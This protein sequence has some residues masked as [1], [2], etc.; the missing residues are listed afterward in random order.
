MPQLWLND[1]NTVR[2]TSKLWVND[3]GTIRE[4]QNLWA[5][6]GGTVRLVYTGLNGVVLSATSAGH[7]VVN[8]LNS[9]R[10]IRASDYITEG[11]ILVLPDDWWIWSDDTAAPA[12]ILDVANMTFINNGNVIGRGGD[13][14]GNSQ[15]AEAGGPAIQVTAAGVTIQN[16]AGA[17]IAGGGGGGAGS[18]NTAGGGG[19]G[20]GQGGDR[21]NA[22][23]GG[24]GGTIGLA[25]AAGSGTAIY[26]EAGAFIA[27]GGGGGAG[28]VNTAG[29]GGAGGGQG[30]DRRNA[31]AG[32]VGGT[33][34]QAGAAGSGTAIYTAAG[35]GA[36]G[37]GGYFDSDSGNGVSAGGGGRILPGVGGTVAG[38]R[39][40]LQPPVGVGGSADDPGN[41]GAGQG[42]GSRG[43]GGG[44]WGA[45]GGNFF[46]AVGGAGG[47]SIDGAPTVTNN[48]TI[49][50][51]GSV[52]TLLFG[53]V[54]GGDRGATA[55][56]TPATP[57]TIPVGATAVFNN[58]SSGTSNPLK[59]AILRFDGVEVARFSSGAGGT[60]GSFCRT[61]GAATSTPITLTG[62]P[63]T[64]TTITLQVTGAAATRPDLAAMCPANISSSV[65][66]TAEQMF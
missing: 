22:A 44:G 16:E 6:D 45:A 63:Y 23:A 11:Q 46:G 61:D 39:S 35:G 31:A 12:L 41:N 50:G 36:G 2:N 24:V 60:P 40:G 7:A 33:I 28:S 52:V 13:G 64:P 49:L 65:A 54:N 38:G 20:G 10:E 30:G 26:T 47:L 43:A 34:G 58:N 53:A 14:R 66:V 5:N 48:G 51:A 19:A 18:I 25:G 62:G 55:D 32:G 17:F 57:V 56:I 9:F 4:V 42:N 8:S 27:G 21:R 29:G 3:G 37:G 59:T 15:N 1:N